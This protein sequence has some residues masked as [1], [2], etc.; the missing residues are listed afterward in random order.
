MRAARFCLATA[1]LSLTPLACDEDPAVPNREY[2]PDMVE[3]IIQ[4][5]PIVMLMPGTGHPL[6]G[7]HAQHGHG[8]LR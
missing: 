8:V 4:L 5:F 7:T 3:G 1:V 2:M 6:V